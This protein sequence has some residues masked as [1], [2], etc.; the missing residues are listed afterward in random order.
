MTQKKKILVVE[1]DLLIGADLSN[2]LTSL[3]YTVVGPIV[4][5][6]AVLKDIDLTCPDFILMDINLSGELDGIQTVQKLQERVDIPVVFLSALSDESTLQRAKLVKPYGYLIKPFDK[7]ELAITIELTLQRFEA[8]NIDGQDLNSLSSDFENDALISS[9]EGSSLT[10][11]V[12]QKL[13]LFEGLDK[14]HL[15][16]LANS[17]LIKEASAGEFLLH[18]GEESSGG[19]IP[20]SGRICIMKTSSSGKELIVTLMAPGDTYGVLSMTAPL[21]G[22][23]SARSQ[24]DSRYI[25]IPKAQ[26]N[27]FADREPKIY[28]NLSLALAE[29]LATAQILSSSLAHARVEE[30]IVSTLLAL[31]PRFG[32]SS[33]ASAKEGRIYITR[34]ELSEL[35]GTTPETAIR[36]TKAL[37]RQKLLDLSRPGIIKIPN[38]VLLQEVEVL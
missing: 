2:T 10:D 5:G 8:E 23:T 35:T 17:C 25:W 20:L 9:V 13:P 30:R 19:F 11:E 24:I 27:Y 4:S 16:K 3:G 32:K 15:E 37:E 12:I 6:E 38:I 1:D 36:V 18:E 22:S 7:A 28:K 34:K 33:A 14:K 21:C 31:L 26:W 29:H